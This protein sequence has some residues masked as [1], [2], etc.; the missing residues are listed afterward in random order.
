MWKENLIKHTLMARSPNIKLL[1]DWLVIPLPLLTPLRHIQTLIKYPVDNILWI[2]P[3]TLEHIEC[4]LDILKIFHKDPHRKLLL[5][6]IK[7]FNHLTEDGVE[8][9]CVSSLC[10]LL[11]NLLSHVLKALEIERLSAHGTPV[12]TSFQGPLF[13]ASF[14]DGVSTDELEAVA[15]FVAHRALHSLTCL[16]E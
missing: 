10:S 2:C 1:L 11:A 7:R 13:D 14:A 3:V 4:C 15:V 6:L 16:E 8:S 12:V 5:L 9:L